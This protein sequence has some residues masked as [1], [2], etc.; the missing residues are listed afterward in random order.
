MLAQFS[1]KKYCTLYYMMLINEIRVL[2]LQMETNVYD[3]RGF[4]TP[5]QA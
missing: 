5:V 2:E 3:P 4:Q 1:S